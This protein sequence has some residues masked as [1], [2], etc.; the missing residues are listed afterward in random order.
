MKALLFPMELGNSEKSNEI[1]DKYKK[2]AEQFG[3][4]YVLDILNKIDPE[5][6]KTL[7]KSDL[8]RIIRAIEI[9]ELTGK[10]KSSFVQSY[11][12]KF[13]YMLIFLND[14]RSVLYKKIDERVDK[15]MQMGLE[16][17]VR[18]L[19]KNHNLSTQNQSMSAI[20]YKEF[21]DYFAG[22]ISYAELVEKIKLNSRH[23][24]KR[25]ITWFKAMPQVKEYDCN[26][27]QKIVEDVKKFLNQ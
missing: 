20:G 7:H 15:M 22:K 19:I 12:S 9:F 2:L 18:N 6:A 21:F 13:D 14:N 5:S 25:Q 11:E 8:K 23:Y 10:K 3:N 4:Q 1:R 26:N 24:A 17:E 16:N 27:V